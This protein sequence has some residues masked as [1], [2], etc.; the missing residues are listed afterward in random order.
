[1]PTAVS[2]T[3]LPP[4][5]CVCVCWR[6]RRA[7]VFRLLQ[8]YFVNA[9]YTNALY[10][11]GLVGILQTFGSFRSICRNSLNE[12]HEDNWPLHFYDVIYSFRHPPRII[13]SIIR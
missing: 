1:M 11:H 10:R 12:I 4:H 8:Q 5:V 6:L 9:L 7:S 2:S 3:L 13:D